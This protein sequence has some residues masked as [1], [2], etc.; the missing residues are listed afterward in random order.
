MCVIVKPIRQASSEGVKTKPTPNASP[1]PFFPT[2]LSTPLQG[3]LFE[4]APSS[5]ISDLIDFAS[6]LANFRP[7]LLESIEADL[8]TDALAKKQRRVDEQRWLESQTE[9]LID[10]PT[11]EPKPLQ[12]KVGRPRI[13][14]LCV[15]AFLLLRGWHGRG[16]KE[17]HARTMIVESL[18]LRNFMENMGQRLPGASTIEENLNAITN[19]TQEEIH[20]ATLALARDEKLD[21][22]RKI[23]GDST[24]VE[25]ASAYPIDSATIA[26]LL[27]RLCSEQGKLNKL[28]LNQCSLSELESWQAELDQL[29]YRI[30]TLTSSSAKQAEEAERKESESKNSPEAWCA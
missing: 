24:A 16:F 22:F 4:V 2:A 20:C 17:G 7:K 26:K 30:G 5:H 8:E 13:E 1:F 14:P 3:S 27:S 21:D 25:S 23:R 29:K 10:V 12:L 9:T 15:L 6:S 11:N 28:G 19:K 18:S